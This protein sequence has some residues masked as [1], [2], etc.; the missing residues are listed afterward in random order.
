MQRATTQQLGEMVAGLIAQLQAIRVS[1]LARVGSA[2]FGH[3]LGKSIAFA[4]LP[5]ALARVGQAVEVDVY[6][7]RRAAEVV[8]EPLYDPDNARIRA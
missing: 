1:L 7:T 6:G 5:A 8:S 3:S 4:Y 2:G